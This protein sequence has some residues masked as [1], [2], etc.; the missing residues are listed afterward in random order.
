MRYFDRQAMRMPKLLTSKI[1]EQ[2]HAAIETF[3]LQTQETGQT[4][5]VP[6]SE[7]MT[8]DR[9]FR[10]DLSECFDTTCAYCERAAEADWSSDSVGVV[11]RYRPETLAQDE[12]G[13]TDFLAYVWLSYTWENILWVCSNCARRKANLFFVEGERGKPYDTIEELRAQEREVIMDP[14]WRSPSHHLAFTLDGNVHWKTPEG[15]ATI[16]VLGL[17][18]WDLVEA[19]RDDV[20][21]ILLYLLGRVNAREARVEVMDTGAP[22]LDDRYLIQGSS[23]QPNPFSLQKKAGPHDTFSLTNKAAATSALLEYARRSGLDVADINHL[24][25]LLYKFDTN[26]RNAFLEQALAELDGVQ[27]EMAPP[28]EAAPP[29]EEAAEEESAA[30]SDFERRFQNYDLHQVAIENFK[31][32]KEINFT[33]P[34]VVDDIEQAPCMLLLGENA[35]GKSSVLEAMI[36]AMIGTKQSE[37]LD[38]LLEDEELSPADLIHRP[39]P[40]NWEETAPGMNI[41]LDF[42]DTEEHVEMYAA[43]GDH[44]FSGTSDCAK[45]VLAYGPRRFF[46][47]KRSDR[48]LEPA[49]RVRSMFDPMDVIANPIHWLSSLKR[50]EFEAAARTWRVV[51]MLDEEDEFDRDFSDLERGQIFIT[52]FG[53]RT[54]LKDL[55][56]GYKSVLAM[57]CDIIRE[58]L[59]HYDNLERARAGVFIDEIETHLHPRWKMQ[60]MELLRRSFPQVQFIVTTHD[61]LCLRGMYTGEV[62]VL[63]RSEEDAS[64]ETVKDLPSIHGMRAE[65]ILTSEFFGLGSTDPKTDAKL[66]KYNQLAARIEDLDEDEQAEM[67]EL[68]EVLKSNMVIGSTLAEQAYAE[69]IM[70]Q[71]E[72]TKTAPLKATQSQREALKERFSALFDHPDLK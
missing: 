49:Q 12:E 37:R 10:E 34:K 38:Q 23:E 30:P 59:E 53:Q 62:F 58:L 39:D 27:A 57:A 36:L 46:T 7:W 15:H 66:E 19:R 28:E 65:Q 40:A 16:E 64:V 44:A 55:S 8:R 52:R 72:K 5:R 43:R 17:D 20:Q 26:R 51:L 56:V 61:P 29:E 47:S 9:K 4:R 6:N 69:V 45:V 50:P 31:A 32:L 42:L 67:Q 3:I 18:E 1:M 22:E 21:K 24:L 33:L 54:A 63:Q 11:H 70:E 14:C 60:I 41:R 68:N 25:D 35:T 2:R 13:N 71:V 48:D